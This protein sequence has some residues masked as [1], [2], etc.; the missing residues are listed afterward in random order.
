VEP[1]AELDPDQRAAVLA[2]DGPVL[3]LAGA[4]SGKTRVITER[5][6]HLVRDRGVDPRSVLAVTFT[7]KAAAE[8][9]SRL[10]ARLASAGSGVWICT[11]HSFCARLLR[12]EAAAAG[13]SRD[14]VILDEADQLAAMKQALRA[15]GLPEALHPPRR[16]LSAVSAWKNSPAGRDGRPD[17]APLRPT[18]ALAAERY[19][20]ILSAAHALDFD[21]LLLRLGSLLD[22]DPAVRDRWRQR[23][24][25]VLVDEYQDTNL[26]QYEILRLLVGPSGNLTVVGDE[27]QSI[28]SWRGAT[29]RN[30]LEFENDYVGG[31][32]LRLERNYRSSQSVLDAAGGLVA[33]NCRRK[34]KI[35]RAA[36]G[37]GEP[38]LVH[39]AEDESAE[40][41]WVVERLTRLPDSA[42]AA[43]LF[44]TNAQSRAFE[45]ALAR[46][47]RPYALVGTLS[48]YQ[49]REVRDAL[50]FA[51]LAQNP[52]DSVA[53]RRVINIPPR[54]IGAKTISDLE[55]AATLGR[56]SLWDAIVAGIEGGRSLPA[57]RRFAALIQ[58]LQGLAATLRPKALLETLLQKTG[59][60]AWLQD[61]PGPEARDRVEN[62]AELV[63]A[64][65]RGE[66]G[67]HDEDESIAA[68]LDRAC[69]LSQSES[70]RPDAATFLMSLHAAKGLEFD[71]VFLV[72]VEEGLLPHERSLEDERALEEERRLCYVGMTRARERLFLSWARTRQI[73][74]RRRTFRPSRFLAEIPAASMSFDA[75]ER[76]RHT[77]V[78]AP[79]DGTSPDLRP[80]TAVRHRE[81]GIGTVLRRDGAGDD[82]KVTVAFPRAGTRR[83]VVRY[84]GLERS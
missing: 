54:G 44:R 81:F 56:C 17:R 43:V 37:G 53:L 33:H 9:R 13:L 68:F 79:Q 77:P 4:G 45:E 41:S 31:R 69:L 6:L 60:L 78:A 36:R 64:A 39:V 19:Q 76:P 23:F 8:M 83:L 80:G 30:I 50:A 66:P 26:V 58:D 75:Q 61:E 27:D 1:L 38:V 40:A 29:I 3:V 67:E 20:A 72:G 25:F 47:R 62:L 46:A 51:R 57:L 22:R 71:A 12:I 82:L 21:D 52:R 59:Y 11:F 65:A 70:A 73:S 10:S 32:V 35:L 16:V 34:G 48:F 42:R 14:F 74:G 55:T 49:R 15:L 2:A 5:I 24:R 84:A 28:Y 63:S 18:H 7:N